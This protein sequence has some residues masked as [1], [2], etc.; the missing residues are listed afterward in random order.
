MKEYI[1]QALRTESLDKFKVDSPRLLHAVIGINTEFG[2]LLLSTDETNV[3][4][5]VGDILWY[6]AILADELEASFD[7][8]ELLGQ[9]EIDEKNL[10]VDDLEVVF[11]RVIE[12]LDIMKRALFYG[13]PI[14]ELKLIHA[15]GV[16]FVALRGIANLDQAMV[17]NISKLSRRYPEKFTTEQAVNRD[18]V[19]ENE[20][21]KSHLKEN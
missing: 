3:V 17:A 5:E 13:V 2:E 6:I 12:T 15:V 8:I 20:V 14:D 18:I 10:D 1:E 7:E 9:K 16:V 19:A 11:E 4:E 21:L